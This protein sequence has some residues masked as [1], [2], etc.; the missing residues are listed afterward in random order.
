MNFIKRIMKKFIKK[1]VLF[2]KYSKVGIHTYIGYGGN[3][4][5]S[6]I[7]NYCTIANNVF[8]GQGEHDYKRVA[9][10]GLFYEYNNY[11]ELTKEDCIIGNDVWI[12]VGSII[13]R[14]VVIGDGVVIGANSVVTKNVPDYAIVVGSPAKVIKYRFDKQTIQKLKK[15]KWFKYELDEARLIV[16]KL[17][18]ELKDN[19]LT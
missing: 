1:N 19:I 12:G 10:R 6:K 16:R 9:L 15:S 5:K 17:E 4:T 14:G 8:I 2:D 11:E 3:I 7:G 13:L 18:Q